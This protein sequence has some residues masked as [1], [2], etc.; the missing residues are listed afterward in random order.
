MRV[1]PLALGIALL[2]VLLPAASAQAVF[3]NELHYDNEG[4]DAGEGVEIAGPAGTNLSAYA[5]YLYNGGT[6]ATYSSPV[7]LTGTIPNQGGTGFGAV[8]FP[9]AGIQNGDPDGVAL[10]QII[11]PVVVQRFAYDGSF[12]AANGPGSN[13]LFS[14]IGV[15]EPSSANPAGRSL[16]LIG[17]GTM[18]SDF[19]WTG[20]A[21]ASLGV[22]N[23]GQTFGTP[24]PVSILSLSPGL[25]REGGATTATLSL[26]PSPATPVLVNLN[27]TPSGIAG[28][29]A[30]VLVPVTGTV[31]FAVSALTDSVPDGFQ[32]TALMATPGGIYPPAAAALQ[33]VDADRPARSAPGV[34]RVATYN[35]K[36]G[37]GT[38]GSAE[39]RAVREVIERVSPDIL[40]LQEVSDSGDF[41][42]VKTMVEQLGF[43]GG[44]AYLATAGDAFPGQ[45][46]SSGDFGAGEC[47]VT[48]SRFPITET[49]QIGRGVP[50]RKELTR[51]PLFTTIDLP[52]PDLHVVNVHLKAST[53]DADNFRKA[54]ECYR[55]RGFLTQRGLNAATDNLIAGGDCNAID[56]GFQ[57]ATSY[58]TATSPSAFVDGS[59]LPAAF[60]LG[61][62][63]SASPGVTLPYRIFPHQGFNP[64]GLFAPA[65]FQADGIR[66][67]TFNLSEAR[68]D[69]I[70]LPQRLLVAGNARGEVYNSRLEPQADG[71]PKRP[72]LPAPEISE[73]ASDHNLTFLDF[74]LNPLPALT[75][76][77]SPTSRDETS[78]AS[79]P[80]V[81]VSISPAPPGPVDVE[82]GLWRGTRVVFQ[83][84][85]VTLTPS[86]PEI[87]VPL[88]VPFSPLVEPDQVL[89]L[90][91]AAP[92]YSPA[93]T[94]FTV[95]SSEASGSL[96]FSQYIEPSIAGAPPNNNS[97]RALEIFN[98]SG[99]TLDMARLQ[100]LVR[101]YSNGQ[102]APA[103]VG[104]V[105]IDEI[106]PVT[107]NALLLPGR[108]LVIGE[109]AVGEA[110]VAAGLLAAPVSPAPG[111]A[112]AA[113]GT[114][115]CNPGSVSGTL[116]AVFLKGANMDFNGDDA[117]D[118]IADGV[119]CD[120]FGK[121]GQ[122]PGNAWTGGPGSPSTA[123]QNLIL[124]PEI[125]TGS[126]GFTLPGTR[127]VSAGPG[128]SLAGLGTPP[129]PTDRYFTWAAFHNLTGL[130]RALNSDPD[131][132][133]RLNLIEFLEETNPT[134]GNGAG[135]TLTADITGSFLTL[136][137][138][139]WLSVSWER[140]DLLAPAWGA[141]S[142]VIGS[143]EGSNRT[144]WQWNVNPATAP[145]RF[146]RYRAERP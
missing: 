1:L 133:G 9:V 55:I 29:P 141:A 120:T 63:L 18:A 144:R 116:E 84:A 73:V 76:T 96:V 79:P 105:D 47:I 112:G 27:S 82:L 124:R 113:A 134:Q 145:R 115:F 103:I 70:F 98:A 31:T 138:D 48:A 8:W 20:P 59:T 111:F 123:D 91:A 88:S 53:M 86:Q 119:R 122:D 11:G 54:L 35:V 2:G 65:L 125:V 46:Y 107:N 83:P 74:S 38:P 106:Y 146:W 97:S 90:R 19:A 137:P 6:G 16:Q 60:L 108:V 127:F 131:S 135:G 51:F 23:T 136:S 140:S 15:T 117:L 142:E 25:I 100:W 95:R 12:T 39:F 49:V 57:P 89:S 110:M 72:T 128:N 129:I 126:T 21:T 77:V 121:I 50:G 37:V 68:Y 132:D 26:S 44:P 104:R 66:P 22:I 102:T 41:G 24:P 17:T 34:L 67:N 143:T 130:A 87:T 5:L 45:T 40:L 62:D 28:L 42:D 109:A 99:A 33:I 118:L 30:S 92:G 71:L 32:E 69:Y 3:I 61:S 101:R 114:L 7:G 36:V 43:P 56:F 93:Y 13:L 75:L 4:T 58:N 14:D 80:Q 85:L 10:V 94:G 64:A 78:T 52:G 139:A 81:T